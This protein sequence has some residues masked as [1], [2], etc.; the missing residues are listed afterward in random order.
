MQQYTV[1]I[2]NIKGVSRILAQAVRSGV[3]YDHVRNC[4]V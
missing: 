4:M 3:Q 2:W 1:F